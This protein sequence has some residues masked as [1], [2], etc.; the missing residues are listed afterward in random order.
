MRFILILLLFISFNSYSQ[1]KQYIIG[2]KGDKLNCVDNNGKKQGRWVIKV[3]SL[4]GERGYEEEGEYEND[5][6]VGTWRRYS[7]EGDI[8]AMENYRWGQKDGRNYYYDHM[9]QALREESWRAIDPLNPY[10]TV[11]VYDVNDPTKVLGKKVV[12]IETLSV[13]HGTW[14]YFD[15]MRGVIEE[16]ENWYMDK[17]ARKDGDDLLPIDVLDHTV[18]ATK[19]EDKKKTVPK[20]KEV[21]EFE[22]G[23]GKKKI[24]VRDG[25]TGG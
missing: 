5:F 8:I 1:C 25:S 14:K 18:N 4:R 16:T 12:K 20:P 7:L 21:L 19:T 10:D 6:K 24:K 2:A 22:Q 15:P 23:K 3:E 13:K 11:N 9:G 17:P